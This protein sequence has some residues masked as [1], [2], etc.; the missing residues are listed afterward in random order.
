MKLGIK[1]EGRVILHELDGTEVLDTG[2]VS[3]T[4][5]DN[6][7]TFLNLG[8]SLIDS[9]LRL[10]IHQGTHPGRVLNNI[11]PNAY[12]DQNPNQAR[13]ADTAVEDQNV[14]ISTFTVQ[15]PVPTVA[16][17]INIVGLC[18]SA[19]NVATGLE[20]FGIYAYTKLTSTVVQGT[21]QTAD[22][23]YRITWSFP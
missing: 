8:G 5:T 19:T 20:V 3:N 12:A 21:S 10:F 2:W 17:N 22:V 1:G 14:G 23:Q 4:I 6:A 16:R 9:N 18:N 7:L 11:L 13:D 15:F